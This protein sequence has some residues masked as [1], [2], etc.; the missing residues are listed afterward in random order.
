MSLSRYMVRASIPV[1]DIERAARFYEE[2]LGLSAVEVQPGESRIYACGGDTSLHVYRSPGGAGT[3]TGTAAT[4][5]VP[6]LALVVDELRARGVTFERYDEP[7]L[8][9]DEKGIH[10]LDDGRVAWF[11]DP[12]GN[13]FALEE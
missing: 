9:A 3:A 1:S 12:D 13:T 10:Q 8:Q 6:D 2:K 7:E 4:W 11:T 5:Y